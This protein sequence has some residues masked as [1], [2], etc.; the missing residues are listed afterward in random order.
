MNRRNMLSAFVALGATLLPRQ[1]RA[2]LLMRLHPY[3][4]G[5][6]PDL[7]RVRHAQIA[8]AL[9]E[10][11]WEVGSDYVLFQSGIQTFGHD[12]ERSVQ[13]VVDEKP[14]LILAVYTGYILVAHRLT[15]TIPIVM[16]ATGYPVEAGVAL[17][18]A[19]PGMNVT[20]LAIYAGTEIFGKLL[21]LLR[22]AKPGIRRVGVLWS[23]V[24]PFHPKEEID[25]CYQE[26]RD[27]ARR[28]GLELRLWEIERPEQTRAALDAVAA[29]GV[30]ALLLTSGAPMQPHREEIMKFATG[31]GLPT[32]SDFAWPGVEPQPLLRY[33]P[34]PETLL[35]QAAGYI[36]RILGT[37][38]APADLPIQRPVRFELEVNLRTAKAFGLKI[39]QSLLLRADKVIE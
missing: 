38:A 10:L 8:D 22:E 18:L 27:A 29:E 32:I 26:L 21:D 23:Y 7:P 12:I 33:S 13:R 2:R 19:R 4:I 5:L 3:R 24:P 31:R 6:I 15:K 20:G 36:D 37:G 30:H 35:R 16:W 9:R 25:P 17:S 28:L 14:D 34:L 1:S 39:P 11:G